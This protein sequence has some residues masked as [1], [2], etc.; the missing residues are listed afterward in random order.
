MTYGS[1]HTP[2]LPRINPLHW[3]EERKD[4]FRICTSNSERFGLISAQALSDAEPSVVCDALLC[5]AG[6]AGQLRQRSLLAAAQKVAP[7]LQH[8]STAVRCSAVQFVSQAALHLPAA[9]VYTRLRPMVEDMFVQKP[10]SLSDPVLL[11]QCLYIKPRLPPTQHAPQPGPSERST[12]ETGTSVGT[13]Q[14]PFQLNF[15][16]SAPLQR[17]WSLE[18]QEV[19]NTLFFP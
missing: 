17:H 15:N 10:L 12:D 19:R 16:L 3:K 13:F 6:V 14:S 9:D 2:F 18:D 5:L 4:R 8:Y 1:S 7:L 11:A